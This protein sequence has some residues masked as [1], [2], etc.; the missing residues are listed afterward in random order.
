MDTFF[1]NFTL[2]SKG[3]YEGRCFACSMDLQMSSWPHHRIDSLDILFINTQKYR[4]RKTDE[5]HLH[6]FY[7]TVVKFFCHD[8]GDYWKKKKMFLSFR[9]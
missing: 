8:A 7:K 6:Q 4:V 5:K 3:I 1:E 2:R 9:V